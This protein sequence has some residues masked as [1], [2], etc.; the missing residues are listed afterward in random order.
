MTRFASPAPHRSRCS[1]GLVH[2][3]LLV[4]KCPRAMVVAAVLAATTIGCVSETPG[5]S[6]V[7][8]V[9]VASSEAPLSYNFDIAL[10]DENTACVINS[11]EFQ[12]HCADR[13]GKAAVIFGGEGEGPGEFR[14]PSY[15]RRGPA[16]TLGV[17]DLGLGRLTVFEPAGG[18]LSEAT[19]PPG[20]RPVVWWKPN[21]EKCQEGC[22][23]LQVGGSFRCASASLCSSQ[24]GTRTTRPSS[25]CRIMLPS[26][27]ASAMSMRISP[28]WHGCQ[29]TC[30]SPPR[31]WNHTL[32]DTGKIPG[33]G[34]KGRCPWP[35]TTGP[36][37]DWHDTGSGRVFRPG[38]LGGHRLRGHRSDSGP[39]DRLRPHGFDTRGFGRPGTRTGGGLSAGDRLV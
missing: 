9:P 30:R 7:V 14:R 23:L 10:A 4:L 5:E 27:R 33:N 2:G 39:T 37:L 20:F 6:L 12:V 25:T 3:P 32:R 11:F 34:S 29:A 1:G 17:F 24:I 31:R 8:L 38:C 28:A 15:L 18:H 13:T 16:G 36:S 21:A 19:L 22:Q 26:C 35:L